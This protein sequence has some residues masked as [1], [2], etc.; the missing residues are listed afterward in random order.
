[1]PSPYGER[2]TEGRV[3]VVGSPTESGCID[4][5][6]EELARRGH[7]VRPVGVALASAREQVTEQLASALEEEAL[8]AVVLAPVDADLLE[9]APVGGADAWSERCEE[10]LL[11][12]LHV[13][14]ATHALAGGGGARLILVL[15]DVGLTGAVGQTPLATALEGLRALAKSSARQWGEVGISTATLLTPSHLF[16]PDDE[17]AGAASAPGMEDV[18]D[19]VVALL[20]PSGDVLTGVTLPVDGGVLMVP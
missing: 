10:V 1:M 13:A 15:P 11:L 9:P 12:G 2:V 8:L 6:A 3:L 19:V 14:Q 16:D 20:G 7:D 17:A 4:H 18:A 5:L